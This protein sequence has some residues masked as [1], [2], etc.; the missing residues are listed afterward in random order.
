MRFDFS[1]GNPLPAEL[2][3]YFR[4]AEAAGLCDPDLEES[5]LLAEPDARALSA[6]LSFHPL[7]R[8]LDG[9]ALDDAQ[10]SNHHL[11]VMAG[12]L[13]GSVFFLSHDDGSRV[14]YASLLDYLTQVQLARDAGSS[15]EARHPERA[16]IGQD[17][18]A[19][20][21]WIRSLAHDEEADA[22][23]PALIPSLDLADHGLLRELAAYEDFYVA[24]A[25]AREIT[26]RPDRSLQ[27][28]ADLCAQH[29]HPQAAEAGRRALKRI[30]ALQA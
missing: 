5:L 30:G 1:S 4:Q 12:P 25:V 21:A 3:E 11:Y 28:I 14:V 15:L 7:V 8:I 10:T 29:A 13:H 18:L 22:I 26:A 24:E 17:P 6:Q 20:A 16:P 19:L 9:V 2:L 23:L 27:D